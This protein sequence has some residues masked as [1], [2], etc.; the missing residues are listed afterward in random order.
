MA[1]DHEWVGAKPGTAHVPIPHPLGG[2]TYSMDPSDPTGERLRAFW[3]TD[4]DPV[5]GGGDRIWRAGDGHPLPDAVD[6]PNRKATT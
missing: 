4:P 5:P 2:L 3:E 6:L 1:G